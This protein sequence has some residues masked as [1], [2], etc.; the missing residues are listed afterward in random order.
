MDKAQLNRRVAVEVMGWTANEITYSFPPEQKRNGEWMYQSHFK[1]TED[2]TQAWYVVDRMRELGW[3]V[4]L[5]SIMDYKDHP[6][7]S[8]V[9]RFIYEAGKPQLA[10]AAAIEPPE[11]VAL[12]A[13]AAVGK[14]DA[15]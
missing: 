7:L 15:S 2:M 3:F 12:A 11:A 10:E 8:Y 5:I 9:C 14:G 1:P 13:L 4:M 6:G